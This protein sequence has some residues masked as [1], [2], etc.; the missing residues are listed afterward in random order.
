MGSRRTLPK[1]RIAASIGRQS[2]DV[3]TNKKTYNT[4]FIEYIVNHLTAWSSTELIV[5]K[6]WNMVLKIRNRQE[7]RE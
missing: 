3:A 7:D 2:V 5:P 4:K 1:W 6:Q